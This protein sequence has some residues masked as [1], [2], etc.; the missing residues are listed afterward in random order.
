MKESSQH[1]RQQ[2]S[3]RERYGKTG[4]EAAQSLAR[5]HIP[6][7]RKPRGRY[8]KS[9]SPVLQPPGDTAAR[10][11]MPVARAGFDGMNVTAHSSRKAFS[12]CGGVLSFGFGP[13]TSL[14]RDFC[15][16]IPKRPKPIARIKRSEIRGISERRTYRIPQNSIRAT[17]ASPVRRSAS[18]ISRCHDPSS[19]AASVWS[20]RI[21][22]ES[23]ST[24]PPWTRPT[25]TRREA[26]RPQPRR[27]APLKRADH[28]HTSPL[29]PKAKRRDAPS[30]ASR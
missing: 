30:T 21:A 28:T 6:G 27:L 3:G 29:R 13:S 20:A 7:S 22:M 16:F 15:R 17:L 25:I 11:Q 1:C 4:A 19:P 26:F 2:P 8:R 23:Y 24:P 12:P 10:G 14:T 5:R 18:G 9:S